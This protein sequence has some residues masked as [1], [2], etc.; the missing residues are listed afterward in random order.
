MGEVGV[1]LLDRKAAQVRLA[2]SYD[3]FYD[4]R[5]TAGEKRHGAALFA[6]SSSIT[7]AVES[8]LRDVLVL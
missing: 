4:G 1:D 7:L 2:R 6:Q 8:C 3:D 5:R